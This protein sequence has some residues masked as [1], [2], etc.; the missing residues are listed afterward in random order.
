M[1]GWPV[2][3]GEAMAASLPIV[4]TRH[5][6]IVDQVDEGE[7]GFLCDEGDWRQMGR[8][9]ICLADN[10][11]LRGHFGTRSLEKVLKVD[12]MIQI[13][14]LRAFMNERV[15]HWGNQSSHRAA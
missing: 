1:E 5:A 8:D 15:E 3:I 2:V 9:M 10:Q 4:A 7:N 13:E 11:S 6:G 12:A 14:R